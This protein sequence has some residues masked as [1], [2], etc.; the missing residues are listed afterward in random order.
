MKQERRVKETL[1]DT[2]EGRERTQREEGSKRKSLK[3]QR[4]RREEDEDD[5]GR[6]RETAQ[7]GD[8]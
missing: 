6:R 1:R 5:E 3:H 2:Q 7:R 8:R 4:R